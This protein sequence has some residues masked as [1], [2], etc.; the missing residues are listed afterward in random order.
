MFKPLTGDPSLADS[1][2]ALHNCELHRGIPATASKP[3]GLASRDVSRESTDDMP[4]QTQEEGRAVPATPKSVRVWSIAITRGLASLAPAVPSTTAPE[5]A[6]SRAPLWQFLG[7]LSR[8]TEPQS[9]FT[10]LRRWLN[11]AAC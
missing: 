1:M 8:P 10:P 4:I 11:Q 6:T 9:T 3:G 5:T 7:N 2:L